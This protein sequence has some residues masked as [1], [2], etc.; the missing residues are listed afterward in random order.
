MI[1]LHNA[2][3][4]GEPL[5]D[6]EIINDY[7]GILS[8]V[9]ASISTGFVYPNEGLYSLNFDEDDASCNYAC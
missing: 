7:P 3:N 4:N 8:S 2:I 9:S 6:Q 1:S 5:P